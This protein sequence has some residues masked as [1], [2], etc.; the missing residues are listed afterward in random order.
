MAQLILISLEVAS[1]NEKAIKLY[2]KFDYIKIGERK[3]YY[4]LDS[5]KENALLFKKKFN[6]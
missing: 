3:Q 6:D 5:H 1:N 4:N 2:K